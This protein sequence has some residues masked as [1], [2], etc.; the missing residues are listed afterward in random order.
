MTQTVV[1]QTFDEKVQLCDA[2]HGEKG[3]PDDKTIPILWGQHAGY[4]YLQLR[5]YSKGTRANEQMKAIVEALDRSDLLRLAEYYAKK[6]WPWNPQP[7]AD[8]EVSAKAARA[9]VALACTSCH[10]SNY[11]GDSTNPRL[12]GQ[13]REYL[14]KS[15]IEIRNGERANNPGMTSLMRAASDEDITALAEF[16]AGLR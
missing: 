15:M 3:M 13:T 8:R 11:L 6:P 14:E 1:G 10:Q 5:D 2:C 16:L 9:N 12:A 4:T 7:A